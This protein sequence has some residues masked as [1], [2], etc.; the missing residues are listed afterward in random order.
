MPSLVD[1][2][3]GC[4]G[5]TAGF[6]AAGFDPV[7]AVEC[8]LPAAATY[9]ANFGED[10]VFRGDIA[11]LP[12]EAIP[13]VDV[14]IGGPPC[15]GFSNLGTRDPDDPRNRLW[16][17]Y[18]RVVQRARPAVFVI[19]NVDR[20]HTSAE[21]ALLRAELGDYEFADGVLNAAD[22]GVPQRRHRTIVVGSRVGA[23]RLPEPMHHGNWVP[24]RAALGGL[25]RQPADVDL[26]G[27]TDVYFGTRV[28]GTFKSSE[29]H[30]GRRPAPI[31][32]ERYRTIPLGG[33]R[34]DLAAARPDLLPPCW[35]KKAKGT[36][37]V[38]GRLWWDQPS[39]TIRTEFYKPEKGRY[40]HPEEHRPITHLEAARLQTFP[41][42]FLWCGS[43]V[44][45]AK[46]IGN[47]VPTL[48][49]RHIAETVLDLLR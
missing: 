29:I 18:V 43:K 19:E 9:A 39:V 6:T 16:R 42:D 41:P 45:I 14:V 20:F 27:S 37:D 24:V 40:L 15:Q 30:V 33:N 49:A 13:E 4:G 48:L 32:M 11:A 12:D 35:R 3:S 23:P 26:P 44:A 2:F 17:E 22:Y 36:T 8:D 10:H 7:L 31:S 46:Q 21:F 5:M 25:P 34:F 1:L 28:P 47:A 38:M